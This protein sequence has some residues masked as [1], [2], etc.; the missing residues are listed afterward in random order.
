MYGTM[1]HQMLVFFFL[2]PLM[3]LSV[4]G[5]TEEDD[6]EGEG[7]GENTCYRRDIVWRDG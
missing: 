5:L 7:E 4:S 2:F 6:D 1:I 3:V